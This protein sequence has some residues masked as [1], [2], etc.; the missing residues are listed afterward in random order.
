MFNGVKPDATIVVSLVTS[1]VEEFW[2]SKVKRENNAK[3]VYSR[4]LK[5]SLS[6]EK[7]GLGFIKINSDG[8]FRGAA[9]RSGVGVVCR[10]AGG[11]FVGGLGKSVLAKSPFMAEGMALR[12]AMRLRGK[13]LEFQVIFETDCVEPYRLISNKNPDGCDWRYW[14]LINEILDLFDSLE[15]VSL[16]LVARSGNKVADKLAMDTAKKMLQHE[17][18]DSP[19]SSLCNILFSDSRITN[20]KY[21]SG[22]V[23]KDKEGI[24]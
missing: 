16:S 14:D 4:R 19:S 12:E 7:P 21:E 22:S 11:D 24:G 9:D 10:N 18:L 8:A 3:R 6:W 5:R 13:F 23:S 20:C 1:Q 2:N 15:G 17:W